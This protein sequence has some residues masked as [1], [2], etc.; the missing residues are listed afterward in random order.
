[1]KLSLIR[2]SACGD[3]QTPAATMAPIPVAAGIRFFLNGIS[4]EYIDFL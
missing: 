2:L 3:P 1:M 4:L